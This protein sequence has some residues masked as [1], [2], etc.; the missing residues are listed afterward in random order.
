M[1]N[2]IS[3]CSFKSYIPVTYYA[4]C[5]NENNYSQIVSKE[6][7]RKCQS[8]VVR[9]LNGTAKNMKCPEF[10]NMY[11]SYDKGYA[12]NPV[13]HS[14]YD[15]DK[16]IVHMVTGNDVDV[17]RNFA[18]NVGQTKHESIARIG[19]SESYESKKA[20]KD[21][22]REVKSF[23][24]NNCRR[25]KNSENEN[26]SLRVYFDTPLTKTGTIKAFNFANARFVKDGE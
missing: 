21:Y 10:V 11:K 22:F 24:K 26:L 25:V 6:N 17:V 5:P 23:I 8:F 12:Y 13:V 2:K 18:K 3:Q 4:K 16:P 15:K 7:M 20:A 19:K 1:L 9:N 14:V